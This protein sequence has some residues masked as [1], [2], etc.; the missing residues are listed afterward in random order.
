MGAPCI[1]DI[2]HLRVKNEKETDSTESSL[3]MCVHVVHSLLRRYVRTLEEKNQDL[4]FM[5]PCIIII[6]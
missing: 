3:E 5:G 6:L 2:S 1:Y 4:M